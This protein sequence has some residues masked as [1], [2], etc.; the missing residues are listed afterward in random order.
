MAHHYMEETP[1]EENEPVKFNCHI[2][3]P[4]NVNDGE[5][6]P[7]PRECDGNTYPTVVAEMK[8]QPSAPPQHRASCP[9]P[10]SVV[11]A[12]SDL[13]EALPT[14]MVAVGV[15]YIIGVVTGA[16]VF[17]APSIELPDL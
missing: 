4:E 17:S 5:I 1:K 2:S 14:L 15:A 3:A 16:Y 6:E 10:A 11:A 9:V 12:S 7:T 8:K 13:V